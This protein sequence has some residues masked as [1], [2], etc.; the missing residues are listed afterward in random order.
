MMKDALIAF[1]NGRQ[2]NIFIK[3]QIPLD[4]NDKTSFRVRVKISNSEAN[5]IALMK[6][7]K[8]SYKSNFCKQVLRNALLQ[9]NLSCYMADQRFMQLQAINA[10]YILVNGNVKMGDYYKVTEQNKIFNSVTKESKPKE[11]KIDKKVVQAVQPTEIKENINQENVYTPPIHTEPER[12]EE[13]IPVKEERVEIV[14]TQKNTF[15]EEKQKQ[16]IAE[17]DTSVFAKDNEK[18]TNDSENDI[19]ALLQ[20]FDNL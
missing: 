2:F 3:E 5:V 20:M 11:P 10:S 14:E 6:T 1:A 12:I 9:Q 17:S 4:L 8:H 7:I 13:N 18:D 15:K 16:I 19:N